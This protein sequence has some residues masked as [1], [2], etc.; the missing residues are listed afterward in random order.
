M[1]KNKKEKKTIFEQFY[2]GSFKHLWNVKK[3]W[4]AILSDFKWEK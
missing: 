2:D 1:E 4:N 3:E